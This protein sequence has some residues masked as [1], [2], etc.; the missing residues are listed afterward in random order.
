M[1]NVILNSEDMKHFV[2]TSEA[3]AIS[4]GLTNGITRCHRTQENK[5][6]SGIGYQESGK[7]T[8]GF[9]EISKEFKHLPPFFDLRNQTVGFAKISKEI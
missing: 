5:S 3:L 8:V 1:I 6:V 4:E 9:G 2:G 7:Q